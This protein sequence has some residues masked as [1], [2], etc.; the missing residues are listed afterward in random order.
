MLIWVSFSNNNA[1]SIYLF[2]T[3][4]SSLSLLFFGVLF[5]FVLFCLFVLFFV[6]LG[7]HLW[8]ME[9][10]G[11]EV[12]SELQLPTYAIATADP[13]CVCDLLYSSWQCQILNLLSEARDQTHVFMDTSWV[14]CCWAMMETPS[15]SLFFFFWS[16]LSFYFLIILIHIYINA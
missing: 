14:H 16:I 10:P 5:C 6:F 3:S 1:I 4:S 15:F 9:V 11:L 8:H 12:E 13:S 2:S 7:Q